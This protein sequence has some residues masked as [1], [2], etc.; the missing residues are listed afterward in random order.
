VPP[1]FQ[2]HVIPTFVFLTGGAGGKAQVLDRVTTGAT[3][4]ELKTKIK[5]LLDQLQQ[6]QGATPAAVGATAAVGIA[7]DAS[8]SAAAA[9]AAAALR[10]ISPLVNAAHVV[11]F[12]DG[13]PEAP[14]SEASGEA[15]RL[16]KACQF[17]FGHYDVKSSDADGQVA[18]AL[19]TLASPSSSSAAAAGSPQ[20]FVGGKLVGDHT[21]M[22][23]LHAEGALEKLKPAAAP[24]ASGSGGSGVRSGDD[25][26]AYLAQLIAK[27][28][29]TLF[30]KGTPQEP[31]CGFSRKIVALL[32]EHGVEFG[33]FN[34]LSDDEVREG[35]KL[36]SNW[37]V[38]L[39]LV[40]SF[41]SF[42]LAFFWRGMV[43]HGVQACAHARG[44]ARTPGYRAGW[45][46]ACLP[47]CLRGCARAGCVRTGWCLVWR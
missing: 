18:R 21:R 25:L 5:S 32:K 33:S 12:M 23:A 13:T 43:W 37:R 27:D 22:A 19:A 14:G 38:L 39:F 4:R 46:A 2:V 35:L 36:Y 42:F 9:T 3:P 15:V 47:R 31:R 40:C 26:N 8:A 28:E 24:A 17:K 45:L 1:R 44:G 34:I 16:L 29:V 20:L 41:D 11:L 10:T 7:A 30:M 6:R